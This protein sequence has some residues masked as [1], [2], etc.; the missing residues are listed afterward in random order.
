MPDP[1]RYLQQYAPLAKGFLRKPFAKAKYLPGLY[2]SAGH[3]SR[4]ITS[5]CL[6]AEIIASYVSGE[7]QAIDSEV[8]KAIHPARFLVR[9]IIRRKR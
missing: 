1:D 9:D 2:V 5:T 6:A 7:P 8:L 3:G 4:G